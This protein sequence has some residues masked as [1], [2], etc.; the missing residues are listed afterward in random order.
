MDRVT[1]EYI[2]KGVS[3]IKQIRSFGKTSNF[4]IQ[5][6]SSFGVMKHGVINDS[7]KWRVVIF[8]RKRIIYKMPTPGKCLKTDLHYEPKEDKRI[9]SQN[10]DLNFK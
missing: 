5:T 2:Q 10:T 1:A 7:I 6:C 8:N 4:R 3:I 9:E